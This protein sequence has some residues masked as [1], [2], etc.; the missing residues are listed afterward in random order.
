MRRGGMLLLLVLAGC[1][2]VTPPTPPAPP[3]LSP[4]IPTAAV[5]TAVYYSYPSTYGVM[6]CINV[7]PTNGVNYLC[8]YPPAVQ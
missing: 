5:P 4:A 8:Y 2:V 1:K 7:D 3:P 6:L